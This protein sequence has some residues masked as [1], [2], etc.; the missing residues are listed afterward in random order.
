MLLL[1]LLLPALACR[2]AGGPCRYVKFQ[3]V[4]KLSIFVESNQ[5]A[6]ETTQIQKIAIFGSTGGGPV[7]CDAHRRRTR[8]TWR[9]WQARRWTCGT[10]RTRP[11]SRT[12]DRA[13][14]GT[15]VRG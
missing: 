10:S 8:L 1:L 6:E 15:G 11:S 12:G 7:C 5:G 13:A 4:S 2:L 14:A 9:A 3:T